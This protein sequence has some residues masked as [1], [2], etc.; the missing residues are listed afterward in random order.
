MEWNPSSWL[1]NLKVGDE[2]ALPIRFGRGY[3]IEKVVRV[4]P[5]QVIVG[6]HE[7]RFRKADGF[8]VGHDTWNTSL[9]KPVTDQVR[10]TNELATLRE[11]AAIL[12]NNLTMPD[13]KE[14]LEKL[15]AALEPFVKTN[16]KV[17]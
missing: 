2:V 3:D 12:R 9:I 16:P 11:K 8:N 1:Q 7:K 13:D 14:S 5:T 10:L 4:T 17:E 6:P 15:I